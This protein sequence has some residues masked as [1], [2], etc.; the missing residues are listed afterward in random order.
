MSDVKA[1]WKL[2]WGITVPTDSKDW[3][4][5]LGQSCWSNLNML[6]SWH[7]LVCCRVDLNCEYFYFTIPGADSHVLLLGVWD[8]FHFDIGY[9]VSEL[10]R[11]FNFILNIK[12]VWVLYLRCTEARCITRYVW[13]CSCSEASYLL[14][15]ETTCSSTESTHCWLSKTTCC[16]AKT[17]GSLTDKPTSCWL[18]KTTGRRRS[19]ST[20]CRSS[21]SSGTWLLLSKSASSKGTSWFLAEHFVVFIYFY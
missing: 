9:A 13:L 19:K 2:H 17:L 8:D 5:K 4:L 12:L 10:M 21:K 16:P 1:W 3:A 18:S 11:N 6:T 20:S 14:A 7:C 15:A